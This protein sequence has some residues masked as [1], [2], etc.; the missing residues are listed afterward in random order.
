ML[1]I[2]VPA[3]GGGRTILRMAGDLIIVVVVVAS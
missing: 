2:L 1:S 3:V